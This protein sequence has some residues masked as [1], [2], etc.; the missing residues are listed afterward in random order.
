MFILAELYSDD[1][2]QQYDRARYYYQLILNHIDPDNIQAKYNLCILWHNENNIDKSIDC[3]EDLL[4]FLSSSSPLN[5]KSSTT[6]NYLKIIQEQITYLW[7]RK[8]F[9]QMKESIVD[10]YKHYFDDD[11][12]D[13]YRR[14]DR[15]CQNVSDLEVFEHYFL[16]HQQQQ[17]YYMTKMCFI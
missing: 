11:N 4:Q 12:D 8:N 13:E 15:Q 6:Q 16:H 5:D 1:E 9:N 17:N 3:F 2:L 7:N 10:E 14:M